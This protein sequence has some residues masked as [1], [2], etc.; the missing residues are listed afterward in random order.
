MRQRQVAL[1]LL[2]GVGHDIAAAL[3]WRRGTCRTPMR[4]KMTAIGSLSRVL[5]ASF[6]HVDPFRHLEQNSLPVPA[7]I[8]PAIGSLDNGTAAGTRLGELTRQ[9]RSPGIG[10]Q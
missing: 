2:S 3:G 9:R 4:H 8:S 6:R 7:R 5:E 10:C 1:V